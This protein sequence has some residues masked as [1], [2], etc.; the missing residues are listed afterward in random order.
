MTPAENQSDTIPDVR[1]V[2]AI[3]TRVLGVALVLLG[4]TLLLSPGIPYERSRRIGDSNYS[5]KSE[6]FLVIRRPVA[7]LLV[8]A[9]VAALLV[10]SRKANP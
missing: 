8:V 10:A 6:H 2:E 7:G 4:L 3:W 9:G 1:R 5:V